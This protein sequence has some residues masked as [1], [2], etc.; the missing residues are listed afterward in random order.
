MN[1]ITPEKAEH[2]SLF[3]PFLCSQYLSYVLKT[4]EISTQHAENNQILTPEQG[5]SKQAN[6]E[7]QVIVSRELAPEKSIELDYAEEASKITTQQ[8]RNIPMHAH[9]PYVLNIEKKF[10]Q[11]LIIEIQ[12]IP[13][14]SRYHQN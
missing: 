6:C 7:L 10:S 12:V 4:S 14:K 5:Q 1:W 13:P 9:L 8:R 3:T 2:L 11:I